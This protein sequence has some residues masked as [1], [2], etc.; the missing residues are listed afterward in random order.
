MIATD[1]AVIPAAVGVDIGCGINAVRLSLK[2]NDLPENLALIRHQIERDVPLGMGPAGSHK[3]KNMPKFDPELAN[4][5]K[6]ITA[7]H[8]GLE[9]TT[10]NDKL[11]PWAQATTLLKSAWIKMTM[12]G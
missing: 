9:K 4:R 6:Q 2:A 1:H 7:K 8:P 3:H 11:A 5:L 12:S 10:H